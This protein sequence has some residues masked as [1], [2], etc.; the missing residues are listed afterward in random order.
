L[1]NEHSITPQAAPRGRFAP[2]PSGPLHLG[3]LLTALASYLSVRQRGGEW[4][5]RVDDLD[6]PRCVPG[7][8]AAIQRQLEAHGLW[9][10][11]ALVMQSA[12]LDAY[13]AELA[14][15]SAEGLLYACACTRA[16]LAATS[17]QG[18]DGPIYPGTCR[19]LALPDTGRIALRF[20][21]PP[22]EVRWED[23][24]QGPLLRQS[25]QTLGDAVVRRADGQMGYHLACV[26][27]EARMGITEVVRGADLIGSSAQQMQ[28]M[29][30]LALPRPGYAHVPVLSSADGRKLSK[31]N[32]AAALALDTV[33]CSA[34]LFTCLGHLGLTSPAALHG[35]PPTELLAWALAQPRPWQPRAITTIVLPPA[36]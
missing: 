34:Q 24:F 10:D 25:P 27:D 2:T 26:L 23:G 7:A 11:G 21:A 33:S 31:Q 29:D 6:T 17:R 30:A 28:L 22:G 9:W 16:V 4:W 14:R 35:A 8:V 19:E 36:G 32:G 12:H 13:A 3:S 15:L 18:L 1:P 20:R 5:L